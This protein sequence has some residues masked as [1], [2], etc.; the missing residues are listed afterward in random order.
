MFLLIS[1][2]S[3]IEREAERRQEGWREMDMKICAQCPLSTAN[4]CLSVFLLL[5]LSV[6]H[7]LVQ[8]PWWWRHQAQ[9]VL[10]FNFLS[11]GTFSPSYRWCHWFSA[12]PR[13]LIIDFW[14]VCC[15]S[16][17]ADSESF[18]AWEKIHDVFSQCWS[19]WSHPEWNPALQLSWMRHYWRQSMS[20]QWTCFRGG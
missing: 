1:K 19:Q 8:F 18:R 17:F 7:R 11:S 5:S 2:G 3:Y 4:L 13:E 14:L 9:T 6:F 12:V 15:G 10:L 20:V 16:C